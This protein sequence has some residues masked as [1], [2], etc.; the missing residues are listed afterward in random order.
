MVILDLGVRR[1][2]PALL[3]SRVTDDQYGR[4]V[5]YASAVIRGDRRRM[6][7]ELTASLPSLHA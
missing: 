2:S 5:E 6:L 1:K 3:V 4:T 7:V